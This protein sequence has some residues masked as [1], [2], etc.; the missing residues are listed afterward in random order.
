V[1][2]VPILGSIPLIGYLFQ[3]HETEVTKRDLVIEV[4]PHILAEQQ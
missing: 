1:T 2:K 4:T 3:H